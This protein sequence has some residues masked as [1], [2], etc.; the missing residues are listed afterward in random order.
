[1]LWSGFCFQAATLLLWCAGARQLLQACLELP[2]L[3]FGTMPHGA[4]TRWPQRTPG[5]VPGLAASAQRPRT[6]A[7][8]LSPTQR[9]RP[10][11]PGLALKT[12]HATLAL[13]YGI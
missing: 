9:L 10:E 11:C 5:L 6:E 4:H 7:A 1:M 2:A 3:S 12:G 13:V 8:L